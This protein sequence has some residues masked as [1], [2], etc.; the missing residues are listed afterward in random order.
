M[1]VLGG[2]RFETHRNKRPTDSAAALSG[3]V[4]LLVVAA[5]AAA[6]GWIPDATAG[7][8]ERLVVSRG[9][10]VA[11]AA[12]GSER[13][14]PPPVRPVSAAVVP[15]ADPNHNVEMP[16]R[17]P[18]QKNSSLPVPQSR[19]ALLLC[20]L[21]TCVLALCGCGIMR[22]WHCAVVALCGCGIVRLW[23][24]AVVALKIAATYHR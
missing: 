15:T 20:A 14:Q 21:S 3:C 24:C 6:A 19:T 7:L 4:A 12:A 10:A 23:H 11:V 18:H 2:T 5:A 8:S 22:L 16:G 13:E 1:G 17:S 9:T